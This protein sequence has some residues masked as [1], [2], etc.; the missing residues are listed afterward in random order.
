[1]PIPEKN[2][3]VVGG[4]PVMIGTK[5]VAP[6]IAAMCC[7]PTPMVRGQVRRSSVDTTAPALT[8]LPFPWSFHESRDN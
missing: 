6:N 1:V 8:D 7:R 4:K 3:V 5:K 2:R